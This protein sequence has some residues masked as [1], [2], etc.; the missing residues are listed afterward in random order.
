VLQ[1]LNIYDILREIEKNKFTVPHSS[2]RELRE[3]FEKLP[4]KV[5]FFWTFLRA[6]SQNKKL[7]ILE[8]FLFLVLL[9]IHR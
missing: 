7:V 6:R 1:Y 3:K 9:E 2:E 8:L 5:F 4:K